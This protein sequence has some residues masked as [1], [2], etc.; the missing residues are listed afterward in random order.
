MKKIFK[1]FLLIYAC[2][3]IISVALKKFEIKDQEIKAAELL[4]QYYT[5][6]EKAILEDYFFIQSQRYDNVAK[7]IISDLNILLGLYISQIQAG[8]FECMWRQLQYLILPKRYHINKYVKYVICSGYSPFSLWW[9]EN[10]LCLCLEFDSSYFLQATQ[11]RQNEIL[12][13]LLF[14]FDDVACVQ[15]LLSYEIVFQ[16]YYEIAKKLLIDEVGYYAY[17]SVKSSKLLLKLFQSGFDVNYISLEG[18]NLLIDAILDKAPLAKIKNLLDLGINKNYKNREGKTA[19]DFAIQQYLECCNIA[20]VGAYRCV[21]S[22]CK[23]LE[24]KAFDIIKF[25]NSHQVVFDPY[26]MN[27][28]VQDIAKTIK[29][30][31]L[32][33]LNILKDRINHLNQIVVGIEESNF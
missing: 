26:I 27:D 24:N 28:I 5:T 13:D 4:E 16:L 3:V 18:N 9:V 32:D 15:K 20:K 19:L 7:W 21:S 29:L 33:T 14:N 6:K 17:D 22:E 31:R 1:Y 30:T 12:R 2:T 8:S 11:Y 10:D 23:L 25:L